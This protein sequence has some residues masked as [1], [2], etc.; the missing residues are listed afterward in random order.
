MEQKTITLVQESFEKVKPIAA[1]AAE[2]FYSKLFELDPALKPLFPSGEEAMKVQGNKLMTMLAAAVVG[3]SNLEALIPVLQDLGKR[4]VGYNVTPE[5][6]S[7]V[8]AALLDTLA[9]GLGDDF[10]PEVKEAWASVYGTM[11]TVMIEAS[12]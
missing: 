9:T 5:H 6:Y 12:Y 7:T 1:T 4:H 11:S 3:L 2:I 8:G 10:T